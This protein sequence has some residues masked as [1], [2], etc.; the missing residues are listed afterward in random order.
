[1]GVDQNGSILV[2]SGV[3][4]IYRTGAEE[5]E[6][7]RGIDLAVGRGQFLAVM[8]PS[9]SGK[10]TLLNCLTG[11]DDIDDGTVLVDGSDIHAMNDGA[12]TE[13][14]ARHMGF[15]FQS[16]NLIPVLTAAENTELP[17]LLVGLK[18]SEAR[19]RAQEMLDRVGL[20]HRYNHRPAE[21]SGGSAWRWHALSST[22]P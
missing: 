18:P 17:L 3:R 13:H 21:L 20:G 10:T 8:G 15:I 22:S 11:L 5:V 2:A 19:R 1:V 9:G 6:A 14:R 16:F 7:L 4:K 12:R